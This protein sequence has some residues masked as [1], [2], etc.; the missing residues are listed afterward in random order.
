MQSNLTRLKSE[1]VIVNSP[2][3]FAGAAQR[4]MRLTR[5]GRPWALLVT[6]PAVIFLLGAWW[7][8]IALWY[9][10][11]IPTI[12]IVM[13]PFR[14]LRRGARKRKTTALQHRELLQQIV[15]QSDRKP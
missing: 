2:M 9:C 7:I 1:D 11:T 8:T 13:I 15:V 6:I 4:S 3:S 10:V 12:G 5:L 14:L